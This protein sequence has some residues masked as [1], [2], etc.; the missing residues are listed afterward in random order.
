VCKD[1]AT[2]DL[3]HHRFPRTDQFQV[4]DSLDGLI[5]KF[6]VLNNERLADALKK[7]LEELESEST[8]WKPEILSLLLL[9]SD[10]PLRKSTVDALDMLYQDD[11]QP[12]LTWDEILADDPLEADGV[13]DEVDFRA[14][15]E[16]EDTTLLSLASSHTSEDTRSSSIDERSVD[17]AAQA[18]VLPIH[19]DELGSVLHAKQQT[20][21]TEVQL[22]RE[23][24]HMLYGL[25]TAIYKIDGVDHTI[26]AQSSIMLE[27][28]S[29]TALSSLLQSFASMGTEIGVLR[30]Y[31]KVRHDGFLIQTFAAAI[32]EQLQDFGASIARIE[33]SFVNMNESLV[34]SLITLESEVRN[35]VEQFVYLK[36]VIQVMHG[37]PT[38]QSFRLLDELYNHVCMA[39]IIGDSEGFD[40]TSR[41]FSRCLHTYLKPLGT[42]MDDGDLGLPN[43]ASPFISRDNV[44]ISN[45]W[46]DRYIQAL[47][48]D[49]LFT[50]PGFLQSLMPQMFAS[51]K[52]VA[53]MR[54]LG[55][56]T[57]TP[58]HV[59][60]EIDRVIPDFSIKH[61]ADE[62]ISL[63][64][65]PQ[66]LH[67][68][69]EAWV[70]SKHQH[71]WRTLSQHLQRKGGIMNTVEALEYLYLSKDGSLT[72][73]CASTVFAKLDAG[74]A[75]WHEPLFLEDLVRSCFANYASVDKRRISITRINE[76][77]FIERSR[78]DRTVKALAI[79][80][81]YIAYSF[82]ADIHNIISP[83]TAMPIHVAIS[84]ILLQL[85]RPI[86]LLSLRS[87]KHSKT[88]H[89][90]QQARRYLTLRLRHRLLH[91]LTTI[92]SHLLH[93]AIA[94]ASRTLH[95]A[96]MS[97]TSID[98]LIAA[99][100]TYMARL[101]RGCLLSTQVS[102]VHGAILSLADLGVLFV[103]LQIRL[104]GESSAKAVKIAHDD[105]GDVS[106]DSEHE[107]GDETKADA[108]PALPARPLTAAEGATRMAQMTLQHDQLLGLV[109]AGLRTAARGAAAQDDEG[110]GVNTGKAGEA[111]WGVL[112]EVLGWALGT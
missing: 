30:H 87:L 65:F 12:T 1:A 47:D 96:L 34:V 97:A 92:R 35:L 3:R 54:E 88:S 67:S 29:K 105:D 57:T 41:L 45:F 86:S 71:T 56:S 74:K 20:N 55:L 40:R 9:L 102:G 15:S 19:S 76:A 16:D 46:K 13:W 111:S 24:L 85:H 99:H 26:R 107:S 98:G 69:L 100:A 31:S 101:E 50:G 104:Q 62:Q 49:G 53:F 43:V 72:N 38:T 5:E 48:E 58:E 95:S 21:L 42:W 64:P 8:K 79:I 68:R 27:S 10:E 89:H 63:I 44:G 18:F 90:A 36:T 23:T 51:G 59:L 32:D 37:L 84:T 91:T 4:R 106:S 60:S 11:F 7:R 70:S 52:S 39:E 77:K 81:A 25:P 28:L 75:T 109:V 93:E 2:R 103:Q 78:R 22:I 73:Q 14:G 80:P 66:L 33:N 94:P 108:I 110:E 17:V 82:P 61:A 112:A 83:K 6:E